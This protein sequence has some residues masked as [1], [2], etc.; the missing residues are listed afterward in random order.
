MIRSF[1][2]TVLLALGAALCPQV[3]HGQ[4]DPDLC[5][6]LLDNRVRP[7]LD[8]A[9]QLSPETIGA[10]GALPLATP[11]AATAYPGPWGPGYPPMQPAGWAYRPNL[12][13]P[14][15]R[16]PLNAAT[17]PALLVQ[18]GAINPL[19]LQN[20]TPGVLIAL[21]QQQQAEARQVASL[22]SLQASTASLGQGWN[23]QWNNMAL[24]YE[25]YILA[26][27]VC[28]I[29]PPVITGRPFLDLALSAAGLGR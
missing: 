29:S 12:P 4:A 6:H 11:L 10:V 20:A 2:I 26:S 16:A 18:G 15:I 17:T 22:W 28:G 23:S 14:A 21:A 3:T 19:Q 9:E 1:A 27:G 8:A 5:R 25:I 13:W 24:V 7:L